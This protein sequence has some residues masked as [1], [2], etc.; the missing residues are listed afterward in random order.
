MLLA[1]T[2]MAFSAVAQKNATSRDFAPENVGYRLEQCAN[3][4]RSTPQ[5]QDP[6]NVSSEWVTGIVNN[7]KAHYR[8][9]DSVPYRLNITGLAP[10]IP[11]FV[12][13]SYDSTKGGKHAID[14]ITSYDKTENASNPLGPTQAIPCAGID[15]LICPIAN[16]AG[17]D[18]FP[19]PADPNVTAAGPAFPQETA[20]QSIKIWGGDITGLGHPTVC[21]GD[22]SVLDN[23][24]PYLLCGTYAGN[25]NTQVTIFF[26]PTG[27]EVVLAW[28]GHIAKRL[29]W[30]VNN[31]ATSISGAP[32]HTGLITG[33]SRDV[34][35]ALNAVLFPGAIRIIKEVFTNV[36]VGTSAT[37]QFNFTSSANS[38]LGSF[39]LVDD[40][41]GPG[42]DTVAAPVTTFFVA[43]DL[44][45]EI[46]VTEN[47]YSTAAHPFILT[48]LGCD[49][50]DGGLGVTHDSSPQTGFATATELANRKVTVR[51]QEGEIVTCK[52]TNTES[53][54]R[55]AAPA[56]ISGRA[57]DSFGRGISGARITVMNAQNGELSSAI[58]NSFGYYTV[59]GTEVETFYTMTISHKRYTFAD[60]TRTF[61]LHDNLAGV[62]FIANP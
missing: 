6:C 17:D 54:T 43:S 56:T 44:T 40:D 20:G 48:N 12:T 49:D 55:T 53:L 60:D 33:G 45:T 22:T 58:T 11:T 14:Y 21:D 41:G 50:Q 46:T 9:G 30:G 28:G 23:A 13:I 4:G 15:P 26:T 5:V 38:G 18:S 31:G 37:F 7:S 59:V 47:N 24:N 36:P 16:I 3:G 51:V 27:S 8:E 29:D 19:I 1:I 62:D 32:F 35:M 52:F 39:F 10:N 61:T 42:I 2:A 57:V 34:Q 25:S